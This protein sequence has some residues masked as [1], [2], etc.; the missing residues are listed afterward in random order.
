MVGFVARLDPWKGL[1]VFLDA[2]ALVRQRFPEA[3]FL[4]AGDAPPGFESYRDGMVRRPPSSASATASGSSAGAS[5]STT[6]RPSWRA[7]TCS[8]TPRSSRAVRLVLIEAMAMGCP[9]V[10]AAA[11]G[12]LEIVEDGVSGCLTPPGDARAHAEA[13]CR[14]LGDAAHR[15]AMGE[16][17]RARVEARYS[18]DAFRALSPACTRPPSTGPPMTG[19]VAVSIVI[20]SHDH[21][22]MLA[23][24]IA[25]LAPILDGTTAEII[26]IDNK[27]DGR[28]AAALAGLRCG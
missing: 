15:R 13:L 2:A 22:A 6:S 17:A 21:D 12:P 11:G 14:L 4:V 3:V 25:S 18:L 19:E 7:S 8:A 1:D 16:G 20:I 27:Q 24:C 9:V 5:A 26:V 10:A 23:G 28:V